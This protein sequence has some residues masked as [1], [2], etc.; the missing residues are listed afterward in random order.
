MTI[1]LA[2]CIDSAIL[3]LVALVA[4]VL[5]TGLIPVPW[6]E[7]RHRR[8]MVIGA[9]VLVL[10][11]LVMPVVNAVVRGGQAAAPGS[12]APARR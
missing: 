5:A 3:V 9:G 7:P 4:L 8:V 1:I 6:R 11:A 2:D 12:E 10:L